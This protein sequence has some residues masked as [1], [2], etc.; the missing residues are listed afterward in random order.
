MRPLYLQGRAGCAVRLDGP[1][2]RVAMPAR[3]DQWFPLARLSRVVVTG[4]VEW[5]TE[6]LLACAGRG[7][8]VTFLDRDGRTR[9]YL[10]GDSG[11]RESLLHR[12]R[13][14]LDRPDWRARYGDWYRGMESRARKALC[15]RLGLDP[16]SLKPARLLQQ[17]RLV[18]R[19]HVSAAVLDWLE[20][21]LHD[22]LA[23]L[24]AAE[25]QAAGL[26]A[27]RLRACGERLAL[28]A[29]LTRLLAW[30][31]HLP[32]LEALQQHGVPDEPALLRLFEARSERLRSL[33]RTL[34]ARLH[35]WLIEIA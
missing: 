1:A 5:S 17:M 19:R 21:R 13:D 16:L 20:A 31:L 7:I 4:R 9:A 12:L 15:R 26:D 28:V 23:A 2:L 6:A 24:V 30:D 10:F 8:S 34:L 25:L 3:A 33:C 14:L 32:L 35:G 11:V 22:W 27:A 29:D 18:K